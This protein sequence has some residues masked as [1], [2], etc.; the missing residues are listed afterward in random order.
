MSGGNTMKKNGL[1]NGLIKVSILAASIGGT[2]FLLKDKIAE[3]EKCTESL[4]KLKETVKKIVPG[5]KEDLNYAE[6]F[7]D[8]LDDVDEL[9]EIL[10]TPTTDREYVSIKL[11]EERNNEADEDGVDAGDISE[12]DT[13]SDDEILNEETPD[14]EDPIVETPEDNVE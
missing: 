7:D 10:E 11:S 14:V 4:D 1:V 13:L 12:E 2:V 3:S 8:D 9:E 6:D 5:K